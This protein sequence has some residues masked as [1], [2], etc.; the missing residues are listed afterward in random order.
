MNDNDLSINKQIN[1]G[2]CL[3]HSKPH[4][5][6]RIVSWSHEAFPSSQAERESLVQKTSATGAVL[7]VAVDMLCP[8]TA[9]AAPV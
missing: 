2:M 4:L 7:L 8:L 3:F 1:G 5:Q 6:F 9:T